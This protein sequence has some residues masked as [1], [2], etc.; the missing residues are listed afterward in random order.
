M[1]DQTA[2]QGSTCWT[3]FFTGLAGGLGSAFLA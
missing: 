2:L 3:A 1:L